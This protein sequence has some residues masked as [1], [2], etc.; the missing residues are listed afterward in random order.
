MVQKMQCG[1]TV[2]S[3]VVSTGDD[4]IAIKSGMNEAGMAFGMPSNLSL[5]SVEAP[6]FSYILEKV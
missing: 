3:Q 1:T 6:D 2:D 5:K 4:A